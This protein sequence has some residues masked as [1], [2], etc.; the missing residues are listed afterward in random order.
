MMALFPI[1]Q[2][3][4]IAYGEIPVVDRLENDF[5][6]LKGSN[7]IVHDV[8]TQ[9]AEFTGTFAHVDFNG[10]YGLQT[11]H[12]EVNSPA[13]DLPLTPGFIT[14]DL[15]LAAPASTVFT[16]ALALNGRYALTIANAI[17]SSRTITFPGFKFSRGLGSLVLSPGEKALVSFININ[18]NLYISFKGGYYDL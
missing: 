17:D 5:V 10:V 15:V 9:S 12:R 2:E 16:L 18:S 6:I 1:K 3:N 7:F 4:P 11:S 13:Y 14:V 8:T